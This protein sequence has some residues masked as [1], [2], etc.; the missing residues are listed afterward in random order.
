MD[1]NDFK[2]LEKQAKV[3]MYFCIY[4]AIALLVFGVIMLTQ[5]TRLTEIFFMAVFLLPISWLAKNQIALIR[6]INKD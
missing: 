4:M 1:N 3:T 6:K 2:A 5:G